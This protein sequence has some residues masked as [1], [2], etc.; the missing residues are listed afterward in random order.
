MLID[1]HAHL[2][3]SEY[4]NIDEV[5]RNCEKNNTIVIT[6]A[7]SYESSLEVVDIVKKHKNFYG[8]VGIHPNNIDDIANCK[9]LE[10]ILNE[11]KIV[12]IGEIGLDYH[13][14]NDD[15]TKRKQKEFFLY[16]LKLASRH[17]KPVIIHSR[18]AINDV[19]KMVSKYNLKGVIHSYSGSLLMAKKFI[20][21]GFFI[22]IGGVVTFKNAKNI[23][24]VIKN[25]D[26]NN[27]V[28]ETDSPYLTPEP[29]RGQK[30]YPYYVKYIIEKISEIKEISYAE[31]VEKT[32]RNAMLLFDLKA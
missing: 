1:T 15:E 31:V 10:L 19:Y 24:E 20:D 16:Q 8:A 17:N 28:I 29:F 23:I 27:I 26:L 9:K 32:N 2:L 4:D 18:D 30:N 13:W 3:K 21:L 11:K 5:I 12:A 14:N 22:G 6:N 25:I 7:Y